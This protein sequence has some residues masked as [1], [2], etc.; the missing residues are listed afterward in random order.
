MRHFKEEDWLDFIRRAG[1]PP[2]QSAME[3]HLAAG[4]IPCTEDAQFW[5]KLHEVAQ[6]D[7]YPEPAVA[8]LHLARVG[9]Q[10]QRAVK[11]RRL[12]RLALVFDSYSQP[13]VAVATRAA[14]SAWRNPRQMLFASGDLQ[15]DIRLEPVAVSGRSGRIALVGQVQRRSNPS[16]LAPSM[17]IR[18]LCGERVVE[19]TASYPFGEF[20]LEFNAANGLKLAVGGDDGFVVPLPD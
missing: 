13:L 15:L 17:A 1:S 6:R 4:C 7:L 8:T 5:R 18:L 2:S 3:D 10:G 11:P 12:R 19:E 20:Q 16:L 14:G 9:W